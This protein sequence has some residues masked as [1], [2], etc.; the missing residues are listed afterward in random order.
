MITPTVSNAVQ[1]CGVVVLTCSNTASFC[2]VRLGRT[3]LSGWLA[4]GYFLHCQ[5][6]RKVMGI[7]PSDTGEVILIID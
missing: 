3:V 6:T 2:L 7:L 1:A 4:T 5:L